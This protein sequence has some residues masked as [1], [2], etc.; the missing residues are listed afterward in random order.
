MACSGYY[1]RGLCYRNSRRGSLQDACPG[2][3]GFAWNIRLNAILAQLQTKDSF[4]EKTSTQNHFGV[5]LLSNTIVIFKNKLSRKKTNNQQQSSVK[6]VVLLE[7]HLNLSSVIMWCF[8]HNI[9][10]LDLPVARWVV[11][12][13]LAV[14]NR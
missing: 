6:L 1:P 13:C 7:A 9:V 5:N 3:L 4:A 8:R 2:N 11:F 10:L 14:F 12:C